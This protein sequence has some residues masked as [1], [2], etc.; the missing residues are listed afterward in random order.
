[1]TGDRGPPAAE[2][3]I[4]VWT[5]DPGAG[6][7]DIPVLCARLADLLRPYRPRGV[8]VVCDLTRV[9]VPSAVTVELLARL[10]LTARRSGGDIR[11]RGAHPH[12]LRLLALTGL[13]DAI[14]IEG[15]AIEGVPIEAVPT[16]YG[17]SAGEPHGQAEQREQ[18]LDVEE[19]GDPADPVA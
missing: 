2:A 19:V 16:E 7:A 5:V 8:V 4:P 13:G 3:A 6:R 11:V 14:P 10:R 15:V 9:A 12:L 17:R 18:P 1:M